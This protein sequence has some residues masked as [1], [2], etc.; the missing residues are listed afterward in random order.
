MPDEKSAPS[1]RTTTTRT[2]SSPAAASIPA[3]SAWISSPF[4]ALRFSGRLSM[5]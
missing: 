2:E 4:S 5:R 1:P 3:P